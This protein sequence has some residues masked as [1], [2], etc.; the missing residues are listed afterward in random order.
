MT[1]ETSRRRQ[2][3]LLA[4]AAVLAVLAGLFWFFVIRDTAP[5][6][7]SIDD[8]VSGL[9]QSTDE[10]ED[11]GDDDE[12][13]AEPDSVD[14][15]WSVAADAGPDGAPSEAGYR[16]N[17]QLVDVG[18]KTVVGRTADVVGALHIAGTT[19]TDAI[20]TVDMES[21]ATDNENRDRRYRAA[22]QVD[23]FPT[24]TF[25]LTEPID[26]GEIPPPGEH[27]QV[28]AVGD[29]TV[30]GVTRSV[31]AT[32]DATLSGSTLVIVGSIPVAFSDYEIEKPSAAIVLSLDDAGVIE[33]QLYLT[34]G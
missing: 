17:E 32:L 34:R 6:K 11:E 8:A 13:D 26:L 19:V 24:A 23:Q 31:E 7:F 21:V 25:Q 18:A 28:A 16:V 15:A 5:E 10:D 30:H 22:L 9:E 2:S 27:V 3:I 20:I 33:F 29:L 12:G 1:T 4:T 14:G